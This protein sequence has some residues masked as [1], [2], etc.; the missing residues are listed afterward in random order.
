MFCHWKRRCWAFFI[1]LFFFYTDIVG[2]LCRPCSQQ[3]STRVQ[4][5]SAKCRISQVWVSWFSPP[6]L[7]QSLSM[8]HSLDLPPSYWDTGPDAHVWDEDLRATQSQPDGFFG[9]RQKNVKKKSL[10]VCVR[11][12]Q[13]SHWLC[14]GSEL[15][16]DDLPWAPKLFFLLQSSCLSSSCC[17]ESP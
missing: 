8:G 5:I 15:D 7:K 13:F 3:H 10:C 11:G 6:C 12:W 2:P 1:V 4:D 16:R 9:Q 17:P 14:I